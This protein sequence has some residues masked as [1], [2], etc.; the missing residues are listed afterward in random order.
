MALSQVAVM[1]TDTLP[2]G[3]RIE[4]NEMQP[5]CLIVYLEQICRDFSLD[6]RIPQNEILILGKR[7]FLYLCDYNFKN[8]VRER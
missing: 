7:L 3:N 5:I 6:H 8:L 1:V 2:D 4:K